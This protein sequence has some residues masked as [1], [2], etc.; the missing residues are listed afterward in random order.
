MQQAQEVYI[1]NG[2]KNFLWSFYLSMSHTLGT[3]SLREFLSL[4][5]PAP[6]LRAWNS[7]EV[8]ALSST[9]VF[10]TEF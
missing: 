4:S 3:K 10:P 2:S 9:G 1:C 7:D 5:S 6:A 8:S